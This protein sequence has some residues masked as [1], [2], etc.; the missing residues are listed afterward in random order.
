[1][2]EIIPAI[3]TDDPLFAASRLNMSEGVVE[4]LHID[5]IDGIYADNTTI[6]PSALSTTRTSISLDYHLMVEEP[7]HWIERCVEGQAD[8]IIGHIEM[9]ENRLDFIESVRSAGVG[10]GLAIDTVSHVGD[11]DVD[12]YK[13]LDVVLVMSVPAG[14]GGQKF[15]V[16]FI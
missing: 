13:M 10:V 9:M 1:M 15:Q 4:R 3:L 16:T 7:T 5:I 11:I 14:F 6:E 12:I 8:R 2:L